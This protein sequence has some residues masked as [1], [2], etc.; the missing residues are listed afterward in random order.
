MFRV[1][2]H[3]GPSCLPFT[4]LRYNTDS[5]LMWNLKKPKNVDFL[6]LLLYS[7]KKQR[8][9]PYQLCTA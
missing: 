1:V 7:I 8:N 6:K 4:H 3:G 2:V 5:Y 9:N